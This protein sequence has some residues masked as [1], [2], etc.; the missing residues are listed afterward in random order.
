M[1]LLNVECTLVQEDAATS[2]HSFKIRTISATSISIEYR[3]L[4]TSL[5]IVAGIYIFSTISPILYF[6]VFKLIINLE[7]LTLQ[8]YAIYAAWTIMV[9]VS[10]A[11]FIYYMRSRE[12]RTAFRRVLCGKK[13]GTETFVLSIGYNAASSGVIRGRRSTMPPTVIVRNN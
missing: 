6:I 10:C 9:Q 7:P 1:C 4:L 11:P 13:G 3:R 12:Y 2:L 5:T 8:Q